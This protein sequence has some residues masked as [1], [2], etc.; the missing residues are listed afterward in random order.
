MVK[1]V[2]IYMHVQQQPAASRIMDP[3]GCSVSSRCWLVH[4]QLHPTGG[5]P[6][7]KSVPM[8]FHVYFGDVFKISDSITAVY[9]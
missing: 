3:E 4:N 1:F 2:A 7:R 9:T 6:G 8:D 5:H